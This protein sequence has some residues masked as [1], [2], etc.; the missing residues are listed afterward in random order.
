MTAR[1]F[2]SELRTSDGAIRIGNG[3]PTMTLRVE[4]AEVWN[5]VI[6]EAAP[7][8]RVSELKRAALTALLGAKS[9]PDE[10][11]LKLRGFEVLNEDVSVA[12]AGAI[13]GSIFLVAYRRRRPVR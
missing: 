5:A 12:D 4:S 2:V 13:D 3:T 6:I 10:F 8:A 11:V 7:S 1:P 9:D